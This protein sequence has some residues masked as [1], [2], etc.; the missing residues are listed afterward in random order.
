[1]TALRGRTAPS[2]SREGL[3][4]SRRRRRTTHTN[5]RGQEAGDRQQCSRGRQ[6][7]DRRHAVEVQRQAHIP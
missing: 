2:D 5:A 6:A 1:M 7:T 4:D 3:L